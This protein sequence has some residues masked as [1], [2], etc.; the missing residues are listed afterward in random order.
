[1]DGLQSYHQASIQKEPE[2]NLWDPWIRVYYS[3]GRRLI[4]GRTKHLDIDVKENQ[5]WVISWLYLAQKLEYSDYLGQN[6]KK[7]SECY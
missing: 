2:P 7:R 5:F 6:F 4:I 1:M 3:V